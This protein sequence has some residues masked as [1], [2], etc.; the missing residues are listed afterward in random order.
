MPRTGHHGCHSDDPELTRAPATAKVDA[1]YD[2]GHPRANHQHHSTRTSARVTW[3][4]SAGHLV[5]GGGNPHLSAVP[6]LA[7]D[8]PQVNSGEFDPG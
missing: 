8:E 1:G 5:T 7:G 2:S 3:M 4:P 6:G